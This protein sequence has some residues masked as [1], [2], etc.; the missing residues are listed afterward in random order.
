MD[1]REP[2]AAV[3][4]A[5]MMPKIQIPRRVSGQ[6][7]EDEGETLRRA[8]AYAVGLYRSVLEGLGVIRSRGCEDRIRG[9]SKGPRQQFTRATISTCRQP[10]PQDQRFGRL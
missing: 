3:L 5:G 7:T 1:D 2:I 9:G 10:Q 8:I 6:F 4:T